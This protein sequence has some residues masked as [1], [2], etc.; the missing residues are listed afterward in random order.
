MGAVS[1]GTALCPPVPELGGPTVGQW[2]QSALRVRNAWVT[3]RL[4]RNLGLHPALHQVGLHS[5]KVRIVPAVPAFV[6]VLDEVEQLAVRLAAIDRDL[7]TL[8]D[9]GPQVQ[10][11][12]LVPVLDDRPFPGA[13]FLPP[14]QLPL[15]HPLHD[16]ANA[17]PGGIEE[18]RGEID[19]ALDRIAAA[20][21]GDHPR[22]P[23]DERQADEVLIME[24]APVSY[25]HLTL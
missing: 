7:V 22:R 10:P 24:G 19:Q 6:R 3:R 15:R 9:I 12:G 2:A 14:P 1:P 17:D 11:C 23:H 13:V 8:L 5:G 21:A 20:P 25:T 16:A 4:P 18:G